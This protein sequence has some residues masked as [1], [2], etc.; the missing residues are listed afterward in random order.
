MLSHIGNNSIGSHPWSKT[1]WH[2]MCYVS[3]W[4]HSCTMRLESLRIYLLWLLQGQ[5]PCE[6]IPPLMVLNGL[7]RFKAGKSAHL[8]TYGCLMF[9]ISPCPMGVSSALPL[10]PTR[11]WQTRSALATTMATPKAALT[12]SPPISFGQL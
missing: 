11:Q 7:A 3:L 2:L 1:L 5:Q 6:S 9:P 12:S 10:P 8:P 4:V